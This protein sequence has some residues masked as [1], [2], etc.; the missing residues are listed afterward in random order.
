MNNLQSFKKYKAHK[1]MVLI[2]VLV[3]S[4]L[5]L[6]GIMGF[7]VVLGNISKSQMK[8]QD[9]TIM[10]MGMDSLIGSARITAGVRTKN[11]NNPDDDINVKA[12]ST[13]VFE[14]INANCSSLPGSANFTSQINGGF[15]ANCGSAQNG[16][17]LKT[18]FALTPPSDYKYSN[19]KDGAGN[20]LD[21]AH[22]TQILINM[23]ISG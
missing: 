13:S 15:V 5:L 16:L 22:N 19:L 1:G 6:I 11:R 4:F 2:E 8:T 18:K 20:N 7:M 14:M 9:N 21:N 3:S 10:V 12:A 17:S 23:Y